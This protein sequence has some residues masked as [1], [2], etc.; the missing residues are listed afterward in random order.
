MSPMR[1]KTIM[2]ENGWVQIPNNIRMRVGLLKKT[3]IVVTDCGDGIVMIRP[4]SGGK[5][6]DV[7]KKTQAALEF[8]EA[9]KTMRAKNVG[10]SDE[11]IAEEIR[12]YRKAKRETWPTG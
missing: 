2:N 3:N 5:F 1:E 7:I 11:E 8:E 6:E 9:F 12:E 4:D 10:V